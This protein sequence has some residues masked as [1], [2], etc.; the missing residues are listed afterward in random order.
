MS[1][2][3]PSSLRWPVLPH[4]RMGFLFG[5]TALESCR[6]AIPSSPLCAWLMND[7]WTRDVWEIGEDES[8]R[9]VPGEG[10]DKRHGRLDKQQHKQGQRLM[11]AG[12]SIVRIGGRE[13]NKFKLRGW[14]GK[15]YEERRRRRE[16]ERER[17][18][19]KDRGRGSL[20]RKVQMGMPE[21]THTRR[22]PSWHHFSHLSLAPQRGTVL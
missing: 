1:V 3:C 5:S 9:T 15:H 22:S 11:T 21:C 13:E 16:S 2:Q 6:T 8:E 14:C 12:H 20:L 19:G 7:R 18:R 4:S 17:E 10:A